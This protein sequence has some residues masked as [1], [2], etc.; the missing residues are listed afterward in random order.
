MTYRIVE[1]EQAGRYVHQFRGF[2][3]V[4]HK[5]AEIARVPLD[6]LGALILTGPGTVISQGLLAEL[7]ER[8]IIVT[9]CNHKYQPVSWM[10]PMA[11]HHLQTGRIRGQWELNLPIKKRLWQ[12]V[13]RCKIQFQQS[14]LQAHGKEIA[15]LQRCI[16]ELKSGDSDNREGVAAKYY[17]GALFGAEFRRDRKLPGINGLLNYGYAIL[18]SAV[19]RAVVGAG[20]HPGVALFHRSATNSMPLVDDLMEPYRP[21]VDAVVFG[22]LHKE[23][24]ALDAGAKKALARI[25]DYDMD[26]SWGRSPVRVCMQR[27]ATSLGQLCVGEA[28]ALLLPSPPPLEEWQE[29]WVDEDSKRV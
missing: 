5:G 28:E 2:M 19:A 20:L 24:Q 8:G 18:R 1:I 15:V 23:G 27:M 17:W 26:T 7:G 9:V 16:K 13:V 10:W 4:E 22:S 21:L 25:L 3:V 29:L 11:G 12:Q 14:H 6:D